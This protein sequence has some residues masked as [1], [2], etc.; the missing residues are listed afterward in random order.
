MDVQ[1]KT[2]LL[3][4]DDADIQELV[5]LLLARLRVQT[6]IASSASEAVQLLRQGPVPSVIILDLM[7][8]EIGG[9]DFLRQLRARE[10]FDKIPVLVLSSLI[11]PDQI[12]EALD[13]GADR[14]LT[15]P[16]IA[17]NLVTYIG[18]MLKKGRRTGSLNPR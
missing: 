4:E 7:L 9:I 14:Y 3:I 1:V 5:K 15:K 17:N 10:Q 18:E 12:R 13:A 2:A 16:Y 6:V 11:D 8:P